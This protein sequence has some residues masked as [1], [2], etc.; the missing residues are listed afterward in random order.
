MK[1][2][3]SYETVNPPPFFR[4]SGSTLEHPSPGDVKVNANCWD[5]SSFCRFGNKCI[6]LC[7]IWDMLYIYHIS[8]INPISYFLYHI[9]KKQKK[10]KKARRYT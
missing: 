2:H 1:G 9:K 6:S 7:G 8:Y 3:G 5:C 4:V 10:K